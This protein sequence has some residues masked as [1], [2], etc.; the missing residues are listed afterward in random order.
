M[1]ATVYFC[2]NS[3]YTQCMATEKNIVNQHKYEIINA[4][5]M[6]L[7]IDIVE[8]TYPAASK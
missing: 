8:N 2:V 4:C 5:Q 1:Q 3:C 7:T 6:N